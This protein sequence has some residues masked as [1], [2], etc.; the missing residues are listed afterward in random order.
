M[1]YKQTIIAYI[2]RFVKLTE[3]EKIIFADSFKEQ[4]IKKR[5]FITQPNYIPFSRTYVLSGS[6]RAYVVNQEGEEFTILLAIED[7]WILDYYSYIFQQPATMFIVA[8]EDSKILQID[9]ETEQKLKKYPKFESV[10]RMASERASAFMQKRIVTNLT[11]SAEERYEDF[12]QKYPTMAQR[13]PQYALASF[14]GM[15]PENLS[16]I[17]SKK[18]KSS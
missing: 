4:F 8:L 2:E 13:I 3:E 7:W 12:I 15:S 14:L 1:E 17:K 10:F 18:A 16:R 6:F 5:Q 11:L 9:Y